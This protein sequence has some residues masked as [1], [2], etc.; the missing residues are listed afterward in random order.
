MQCFCDALD[1]ELDEAKDALRKLKS[2]K[3]GALRLGL[4]VPI[5]VLR[6]TRVAT[7]SFDL[8]PVSVERIDVLESKLRDQ[9]DELER[10]RGEVD[11]GQEV[12]FIELVASAK[13]ASRSN[14]LWQGVGSSNFAVDEN[15][16]EVKIGHPG[17]YTIAVVSNAVA[18]SHNQLSYLM[19]NGDVLQ[20]VHC[21]YQSNY[22]ST[23][24]LSVITRLD[25]GDVL[26]V[27]CDCDI[28]S[29]SYLTI[30]RLGC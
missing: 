3:G 2:V 17:V 9:Q 8:E 7:Y 27:K 4:A 16:G 11:G 26:T 23:S 24:T 6:A 19:K 22:A 28:A 29:A 5:R 14:L 18:Y 20:T 30:A 10:L 25:A 12:S 15:L 13:D 21:R 1:C